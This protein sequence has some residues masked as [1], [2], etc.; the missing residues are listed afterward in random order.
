MKSINSKK[1]SENEQIKK[2]VKEEVIEEVIE[3][4]KQEVKDEVKE[5]VKKIVNNVI[6]QNEIIKKVDEELKAEIY[7]LNELNELSNLSRLSEIKLSSDTEDNKTS[8]TDLLNLVSELILNNNQIESIVKKSTIV[9]KPVELEKIMEVIKFLNTEMVD[10]CTQLKQIIDA[11]TKVLEDGKLEPNEIPELVS[12]VYTNITHTNIKLTGY[13]VGILLKL[14]ILIMVESKV[15]KINES[16]YT[17]VTKILDSS[18]R[19]LELNIK[20][21]TNRI[22]SCLF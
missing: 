11:I 20:I 2:E 17:L 6:D 8:N 16:E 1:N 18:I 5:D 10:G 3:Q 15:I 13:E 14:L 9:I 12:T 21:P 7:E 22:C 19:L 4:V